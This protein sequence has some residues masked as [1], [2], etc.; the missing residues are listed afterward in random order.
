LNFEILIG[1]S[2]TEHILK[3]LDSLFV[4]LKPTP[5]NVIKTAKRDIAKKHFSIGFNDVVFQFT[6]YKNRSNVQSAIKKAV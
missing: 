5:A 4:G 1:I 3:Y 2:K 6:E